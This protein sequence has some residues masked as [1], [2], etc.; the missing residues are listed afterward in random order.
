MIQGRNYVFFQS[1][2]IIISTLIACYDKLLLSSNIP[3]P[4]PLP[5]FTPSPYPFV[6]AY[7]RLQT[8]TN[9]YLPDK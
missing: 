7:K 1:G 8:T 3:P 9:V 4:F 6:S 2:Y 5:F